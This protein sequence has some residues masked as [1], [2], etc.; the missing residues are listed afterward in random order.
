[1]YIG[2]VL[3]DVNQVMHFTWFPTAQTFLHYY[4]FFVMTLF[5]AI[6]YILPRLTGMEFTAPKLI[7]AHF[8]FALAG[9]VLTVL[10]LAIGGIAQCCNFQNPA[11]AFIDSQKATLPFLRVSTMGDLAIAIG[12]II[13]LVNVGGMV[14][15]FS[16][17]RAEAAYAVATEDLFKPAEAKP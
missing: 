4:G 14:Q 12:H 17:I 16:S 5:G 6:Y 1:M 15:R 10:P 7:R 3:L 8:W 11:V 13:F 9:I 2:N